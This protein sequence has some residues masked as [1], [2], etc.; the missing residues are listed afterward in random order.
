MTLLD[1]MGMGSVAFGGLVDWDPLGRD[2]ISDATLDVALVGSDQSTATYDGSVMTVAVPFSTSEAVVA[3]SLNTASDSAV[4]S[5]INYSQPVTWSAATGAELSTPSVNVPRVH[6]RTSP[7]AFRHVSS[8]NAAPARTQQV[9]PGQQA[10]VDQL[11]GTVVN[12]LPTPAPQPFS[13]AAS[14]SA[15]DV[16][17][18]QGQAQAP[19]SPDVAPQGSSA[20]TSTAAPVEGV[21]G[22]TEVHTVQAPLLDAPPQPSPAQQA[23]IREHDA[24]GPQRTPAIPFDPNGK[25]PQGQPTERNPRDAISSIRDVSLGGSA[26]GG[27]FTSETDEP[28]V[29]NIGR[30]VFETGNWFA[31]VNGNNGEAGSWKFV[32]PF[33]L[34][35]TTGAFSGGFCCDQRVANSPVNGVYWYLQYI[36]NGASSTSTNGV[37]IARASTQSNLLNN[38]WS[39][40]DLTPASFGFGSGRWLDFPHLTATPYFI[41]ASSNV[42][43]TT[44]CSP[45]CPYVGS[46]VWRMPFDLS[47]FFYWNSL[48]GAS[49]A[50]TNGAG[51]TEYVAHRLSSTSIRIW[52]NDANSGTMFPHDVT[53]LAQTYSGT[54]TSIIP[55]G[56]NW[57]S[58]SD[59]RIQTG[60]VTS[61]PTPAIGF[62]WNSAQNSGAGFPQ[63][64]V[65]AVRVNLS[66]GVI[67]Q[68][69]IWSSG[70]AFH[71]PAMAISSSGYH[72]GVVI[73]GGPSFAP[74]V[75][76][77]NW[78]PSTPAPPPGWNDNFTI[79]AGNN[80]GNRWGDFLDAQRNDRCPNTF[81]GSAY[82]LNGAT[83][84]AGF[85]NAGIDVR[86][87]WFGDP[88]YTCSVLPP[89][90]PVG[91]TIGTSLNTGIGP[92]AGSFF[93]RD[94]QW[95]AAF[96]T[97]H[98]GMYRIQGATSGRVTS[99]TS[100]PAG[101]DGMDTILTL[102]DS[103]GNPLAQN[104]DCIGLYS[105]LNNIAFP[106]NGN[107][108]L[109]V[110]G[111]PNF[112]YNPFIGGSGVGGTNTG[113]YR[114]DI[115]VF[116]PQTANFLITAPATATAGTPFQV[117][118][119]ARTAT[120]AT[121]PYYRGRIHFFSTNDGAAT[122][123]PDYTFTA[124]DNGVH[125]FTVPPGVTMRTAGL[126]NLSVQDTVTSS[127]TGSTNVNVGPA[128]ASF[129]FV[130][131]PTNV[132]SNTQ[133]DMTVYAFDPYG[134]VD[135]NYSNLTTWSTTDPDPGVVLPSDYTF[136][137]GAGADNGIHLF[138]DEGQGQTTLQTQGSQ[139]LTITDGTISGT[140]TT[141]VDCTG[142]R[143][144][145]PSVLSHSIGRHVTAPV[146]VSP[147]QPSI[148]P[149]T[150]GSTLTAPAVSNKDT[151]RVNQVFAGSHRREYALAVL[152]SRRHVRDQ[153]D[154]FFA[155]STR[156]ESQLS[157]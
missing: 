101:G 81:I 107:Y 108:Y 131:V 38:V 137:T 43:S 143:T 41:W 132:A 92:G 138:T 123:P 120:N 111:Y 129:F 37:R 104:D 28:S 47:N 119:T 130:D 139:D 71:Y 141:C 50:L 6:F 9:T 86:W 78:S 17:S 115:S 40:A 25:P 68:P 54:H 100:L 103:S 133:F 80:A 99:M 124:F 24:N 19:A 18:T 31:S 135:V 57:T 74:Q 105:C 30:G 109:G 2:L 84:P 112:N 122:F 134:N 60:W 140:G 144:S 13:G 26:T 77:L 93:T 151:A 46:V 23:L 63:P 150:S 72:G 52:S 156:E 59:E 11:A 147:V 153:V 98:V 126:D 1:I 87:A 32:N 152:R 53:G 154:Q 16:K 146:L 145:S 20:G 91:D 155:G 70:I 113:D 149:T 79:V 125:T 148:A 55:G 33:N 34:F 89:A 27:N 7:E 66:Y 21:F 114:I 142:P 128:P 4:S 118:V 15:P 121:D 51:F 10:R 127:L 67:N 58:F 42:F 110:S 36:Q 83:V 157:G 45:G 75:W 5:A 35:P 49:I 61:W 85:P 95:N 73:A 8:A 76:A 44:G 56:N 29:G 82:A 96:G 136:T 3:S 14:E 22:R 64:F 116:A 106:A 90:P 88:A 39:Y 102:F 97:K 65:Q 69:L 62:M 48:G 12:P 117:T 94:T